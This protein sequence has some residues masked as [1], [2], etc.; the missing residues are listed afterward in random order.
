M[1]KQIGEYVVT[2]NGKWMEV[3]YFSDLT[4]EEKT[5]WLGLLDD[6]EDEEFIRLGKGSAYPV[7]DILR[8]VV[9][10]KLYSGY[11]STSYGD[12]YLINFSED[13]Q[14]Q[15]FHYYQKG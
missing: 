9:P 14:Y 5:D 12:G 3:L 11:I 7:C 1:K 10:F 4:P 2:G 8:T 15:I 13:N 6:I